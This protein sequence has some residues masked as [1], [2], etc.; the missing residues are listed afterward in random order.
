MS[1][2][3]EIIEFIEEKVSTSEHS[4]FFRQPLVGFSSADDPLYDNLKD[5]VDPEHT[6]PRDHL[7]EA[8]TVV[9]FFIPFSEKIV[10]SNKKDKVAPSREWAKSYTVTNNLIDY[11]SRSLVEY[12]ESKGIGA[13]KIKATKP[14]DEDILKAD[15]SHRSAAFIGGLGTFG[16]NRMLITPIGCAGRYGTVIIAYEVEP[17]KRSEKEYCLYYENGT[18][19]A[20]VQA[21]PV[22]ALSVDGF[23]RFKCQE[24]LTGNAN[25]YKD[26]EECSVCGKCVVSCPQAMIMSR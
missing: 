12:L 11:I 5:I 8:K 1:L 20:C 22:Q 24:Q 14:L 15:W 17:D 23:D 6:H 16:V 19:S 9:S 13:A 2:K 7:P 4:D 18:C 10:S 25:L 21:C 3:N 26:L